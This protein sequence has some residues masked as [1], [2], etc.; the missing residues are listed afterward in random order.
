M[1]SSLNSRHSSIANSQINHHYHGSNHYHHP[2]YNH[3]RP[4][5]TQSSANN[6]LQNAPNPASS[7]PSV[8]PTPT[9]D[10]THS[11]VC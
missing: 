5:Y 4:T 11:Q 3:H 2:Y 6:V 10:V 1:K 9:Y 8:T 7:L